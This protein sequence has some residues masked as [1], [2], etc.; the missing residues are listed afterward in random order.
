MRIHYL[1]IVV[2]VILLQ[3]CSYYYQKKYRIQQ[4]QHFES[5]SAYLHFLRQKSCLD[6]YCILVPK[7]DAYMKFYKEQ[8]AGNMNRIPF[9]GSYLNDSMRILESDWLSEQRTCATRILSEVHQ[10]INGPIDSIKTEKRFRNNNYEWDVYRAEG[11]DVTISDVRTI[12]LYFIYAAGF[13]KLYDS[14]YE[15]VSDMVKTSRNRVKLY[16]IAIDPIYPGK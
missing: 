13:G 12:N 6:R 9:F 15:H 16:V 7:K 11:I 3:D 10:I 5:D 2:I 1:F 8:L 4:H 14:L